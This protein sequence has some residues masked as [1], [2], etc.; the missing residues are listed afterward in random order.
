MHWK[1]TN[2]LAL[3]AM[4][5]PSTATIALATHA[6]GSVVASA[7]RYHAPHPALLSPC[8]RRKLAPGR[9]VLSRRHS[10]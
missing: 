10:R 7:P 9:D 5:S 3:L 6:P 2:L 4:M 1:G 8:Q